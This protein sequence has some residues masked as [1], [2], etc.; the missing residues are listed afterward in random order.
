MDYN[1]V[2]LQA[3]LWTNPNEIADGIDNDENGFVDDLHGWNFVAGTNETVDDFSPDYHGTHVSGII[4]AKGNNETGISGVCWTVKL[5]P[6]KVLDNRGHGNAADITRGIDYATNNGAFLSSNS[7][8]YYNVEYQSVKNAIARSMEKSKLFVCAAGNDPYHTG[9]G[10]DIDQDPRFRSYPSNWT[11]DNILS[12]LATDQNDN[13]CDFSFYGHASVDIGAPGIDILSTILGDN[14]QSL[15]GTSQAAPHVAGVAALALG[16]CPGLTSSQL[17][18]LIINGADKKSALDDTCVSE[19]RLNAYNV[20][21]A[22]GGTTQPNAPSNLT[23]YPTAWNIILLYWHDN[24]TNELGFEIQRKDQYQGAFLHDNCADSNATSIASF[25]DKTIDPALGRTYI[26]RVRAANRAG[27]SS[28]TNTASASV[29]YTAPDAPI[30]L[31]GPSPVVCPLVHLY[32]SDIATLGSNRDSYTDSSAQVATYDYRVRANNPVGYS[33][34]S[35]VI[36]I[37]VI[38]W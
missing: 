37:E 38:N 5:M 24:S 1:H 28:F 16:I 18:S 31:E 9:T 26:Y 3:N 6:V 22:L 33:D 34:Y 14:Y 15:T 13:R 10:W 7:W 23:A 29:P 30:N 25:Q 4:G 36:T 11:L 21:N 17:K 2:D 20:L 32:W 27:I 12:V 19:G 35:N 8:A